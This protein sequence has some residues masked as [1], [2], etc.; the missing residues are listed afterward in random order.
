MWRKLTLKYWLSWGVAVYRAKEVLLRWYKM[1]SLRWNQFLNKPF[2]LTFS[3]MATVVLSLD[4][5]LDTTF[6]VSSVTYLRLHL[7]T[8]SKQRRYICN[9]V[10]STWIGHRKEIQKVTFRTLAHPLQTENTQNSLST[11]NYKCHKCLT[12]IH[13][14][15]SVTQVFSGTSLPLLATHWQLSTRGDS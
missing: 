4:L 14:Q 2:F 1:F 13:T 3:F 7:F 10:L 15:Q 8:I 12:I 5:H 6:C 9:L 11:S